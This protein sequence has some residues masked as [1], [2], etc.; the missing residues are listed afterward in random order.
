MGGDT[1]VRGGAALILITCV[2]LVASL[3]NPL[4][5]PVDFEIALP[6]GIILGVSAIA[7][8]YRADLSAKYGWK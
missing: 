2:A 8:W 4:S 5:I 1:A 7:I 3:Y 6:V